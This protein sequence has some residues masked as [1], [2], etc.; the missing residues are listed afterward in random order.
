[1]LLNRPEFHLV[2]AAALHLGATAV[3]RLQ[4]RRAR[5]DRVP[6]LQRR[7]PGGRHRA[8]VPAGASRASPS[9]RSSWRSSRPSR[10]ARRATSTSRRRGAPSS[11]RTSLTLIYTSGTTG[12]PKGVAAHAREHDGRAARAARPCLP[13]HARRPRRCP[14]CPPRT[15]P[16]AGAATTP[17]HRL[18][19]HADLASPT[20]A[21]RAAPAVGPADRLRGACRAS[22]RRSRP[23]CASR[24]IADPAAL[25]EEMQAGIRAKLGLDAV[26][27]IVPARRRSPRDARVLPRARP[28]DPG[29]VGHERDVVLR[30]RQ[31]ARRHPH[32]HRRQAAARRRDPPRRRRRAARP[33]R[34]SS[35]AAT[36]TTRRRPPRRSMPTAGCTRATS[37][38]ST[39]TA[40]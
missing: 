35:C 21:G 5:A 7:Q 24:A 28:A 18:R 37:A 9:T 20:R 25:P 10:T 14:T 19:A 22:G 2:D 26:E 29:A 3:L 31:P 38:R 17:P 15:S 36:A 4:H 11:P 16:T 8:R 23:R 12:P 39:T 13:A 6:V 32:R 30:D 27:F 1:M 33:R 40:T 34:R